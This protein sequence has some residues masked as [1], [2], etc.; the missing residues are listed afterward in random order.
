VKKLM[1][2]TEIDDTP[3]EIEDAF[4]EIV[5]HLKLDDDDDPDETDG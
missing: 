4:D 5:K 1:E 3:K 2:V